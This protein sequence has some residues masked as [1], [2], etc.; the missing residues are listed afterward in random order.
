MKAIAV[1]PGKPNSIHLRDVP[2]PVV[3]EVPDG[4][5]VL[6]KVLQVGVDGTDKEINAAEYGAPP[7]GD[8]YLILG[9]ENFG[10]VE[11][12]AAN[13]ADFK[14]GDYV[15]AS[16]RRPGSSI[17]DQIG[18]QDM[19]TDDTYFERGINLRH[20]FLTEYYA[21]AA[22]FL[23]KVP[24][25]LKRAGVLLEPSSIAEKAIQQAYEIQRRLGIWR[26]RHA[27]VLGVGTLGLLTSLFL[28][29]RG[30]EVVALG[31]VPPPFLNSDLLAEI[32][33]RYFSTKDKSLKQAAEEFGPFD[34]I[35]E[36]TGFSPLVFE[37]MEALGKNG[38]LAMVSIT[39]GNRKVEIP[40]DQINQGFVLGNK[41]AFGSVNASR[42]DF[43]RGVQYLAQ[44]ELG[45][46]GWLSK[47]LTHPI[48]GLENYAELM[49][50]LT[51]VK[52]AIKVYCE[53]A[54]LP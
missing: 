43:E 19:T 24:E 32:G 38:V 54:P 51:E 6:V 26:P 15:V 7:A 22:D 25:G 45:Y 1:I 18:L 30:L 48:Q 9:H 52:G 47:L 41:V 28:R 14:P 3:D 40:A 39:G 13:G 34:F 27:A 29:L 46:P 23:V 16:V 31:L 53:V 36:G 37:A 49:K 35:V 33:V 11:A 10:Q 17:Y 50:T 44:T 12:V 42:A 5:G 4:R 21:D 2:K 20:G 8:D